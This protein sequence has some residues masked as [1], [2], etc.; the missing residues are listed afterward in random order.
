MLKLS[1]YCGLRRK[2]ILNIHLMDFDWEVW[3]E[4]TNLPC[5][6]KISKLGAKRKKERYIVVPPILA[7]S[8]WKYVR[9]M[10]AIGSRDYDKFASGEKPLFT[11][12]RTR[13]NNVFKTAVKK[14]LSKDYT[15]HELR[16]SRATYWFEK[17][18]TLI[19][20]RDLLGHE[21]ITTTERYIQKTPEKTLV[22]LAKSLIKKN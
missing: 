11:I 12:K 6:L 22:K 9:K 10:R 19:E 15:L 7:M 1:Y 8:I 2:E 20:V 3:N 5:K 16:F 13:W 4:D 18:F 21:E 14:C 17:G